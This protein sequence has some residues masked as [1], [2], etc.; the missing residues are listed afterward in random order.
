MKVLVLNSSYQPINVTTLER[1]FKL[2]FKGKAEIIEYIQNKPIITATDIFK[3][4]TVIRILKYIS[5]P[6]R[7][8]NLNR[9]N[10]F[11]RDNNTCIYCG[12]NK[13]LTLDHIKP[14]SRGGD[15]SW[16]NLVTCCFECN[17][18]KGDMDLDKFLKYNNLKMR[19]Q[20]YKPN[21]LN[22]IEKLNDFHE[23]WGYYVRIN[24]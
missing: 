18:K 8:V 14:K 3:R 15:N 24:K 17:V 13:K 20:P 19:Y 9:E 7:K 22:Y 23:S 12:S 16:K 5:I 1:G 4:P 11:K 2:V 21:Y 6:Y 10:I